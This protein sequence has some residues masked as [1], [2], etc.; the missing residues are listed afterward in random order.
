MHW[1]ELIYRYLMAYVEDSR[2]ALAKDNREQQVLKKIGTPEL[3]QKNADRR[4]EHG[5][6]STT[7]LAPPDSYLAVEELFDSVVAEVDSN[8]NGH[9]V[10]QSRFRLRRINE[11]WLLDDILWK[12]SCN[13]GKCFACDDGK[14]FLC[15]DGKCVGCQ[16]KGTWNKCWIFFRETCVICQGS[17]SCGHCEGSGVCDHCEGTGRCTMCCESFMPGWTSI[18]RKPS[19]TSDDEA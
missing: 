6:E 11:S 4:K 19:R 1:R 8:S 2:D 3:K 13:D 14:C 18:F 5:N 12:C 7:P 15:T 9:P 17:G 16:G 10:I